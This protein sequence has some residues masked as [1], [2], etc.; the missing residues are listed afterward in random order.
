MQ[1]TARIRTIPTVLA[2]SLLLGLGGGCVAIYGFDD[3]EKTP[4]IACNL[5]KD[6]P[7]TEA[8]GQ[9]QC[10][11]GLCALANPVAANA[12]SVNHKLGNCLR[13]ICDGQGNEIIKLDDTNA[14]HDGDDCTDDRCVDG[15]PVNTIS[16]AGTPCGTDGMLQCSDSGHCTGCEKNQDCGV[17]S[18]CIEWT[19]E[20]KVCVRNLQIVGTAVGNPVKGD[21]KKNICNAIG[22]SPET[23][24]ADD[25]PSD[26]DPCTADYCTTDEKVV[27]DQLP[28]GAVCGDCSTCTI[29]GSCKS[30]DAATSDCYMGSCV[31]KPQACKTNEE[32]P[33]T[34][35]VDGYCCDTECSAKCMA[36]SETLTGRHSGVCAPIPN[37]PAPMDECDTPMDVCVNGACGCENGIQDGAETGID[38]DGGCKACTGTWN[39]GGTDA[40]NGAVIPSCCWPFCVSCPD[41]RKL[42]TDL[43]DKSCAKG[44][45]DQDITIGAVTYNACPWPS[46]AC[47]HVICKCQ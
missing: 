21:C 22:E 18:D 45:P 13:F 2:F 46:N 44:S 20:D 27:H 43:H 30:C 10:I 37:G 15:L 32:C 1:R 17:D 41:D 40:C 31:P 34:Y 3:F 16:Q 26:D 24:S 19:C 42:C 11:N 28:E 35:C 9:P 33:S 23:F 39:C 25:A 36:C 47:R 38:C 5:A 29:D 6:C 7:G 12:L 8:C 4:P 14:R